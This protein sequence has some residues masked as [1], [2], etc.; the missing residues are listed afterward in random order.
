VDLSVQF[1]VSNGLS[2]KL[3][4]K[5]LLNERV[6]HLQGPVERLSYSTGRIF[7]LGFK[8]ELR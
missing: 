1:P 2:G 7:A 4:G 5:N 6:L 3:D 8:W